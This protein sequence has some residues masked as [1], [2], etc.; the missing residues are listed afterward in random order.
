MKLSNNT[1]TGAAGRQSLIDFEI[2]EKYNGQVLVFVHGFMGFK[3]WGAWNLVQQFF[4]ERG[5]GFCKFN[6]S[7]N[8]GT[9]ENGI[10][11]PDEKAFGENCYSYEVQDIEAAL[12]WMIQ[13]AKNIQGIHLIGHSRGGG[14][15]I[16]AGRKL[17]TTFPLRSIHTWAA[18]SDIGKRFPSE[19]ELEQWRTDGVRY[20]T[21][22][23]THQNLPQ[24]FSL[25][26]DFKKHENELNIQKAVKNLRIPISIHHGNQDTSVPI[27]EGESLAKWANVRIHVIDGADHVFGATHPWMSPELPTELAV[28]CKQTLKAMK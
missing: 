3:D 4:T 12:H 21:N 20:V 22:G 6:L 14:D 7:H 27:S 5:F 18:I 11:F 9:I 23:R 24:Y 8:G 17:Q 28:L 2:P 1:F 10:D 25:Y 26:E 19:V 13:Q 15:V 16:L